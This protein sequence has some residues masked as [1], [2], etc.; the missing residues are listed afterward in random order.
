M[1]KTIFIIGLVAM[2]LLAGCGEK[3]ETAKPALQTAE[4]TDSTPA[5]GGFFKK[6][7]GAATATA[8]PAEPAASPAAAP[9]V[10]APSPTAAPVPVTAP[11]PAVAAKA[12]ASAPAKSAPKAAPAAP[13]KQAPPTVTA[14]GPVPASVPT[15]VP[16]KKIAAENEPVPKLGPVEICAKKANAFL[17]EIC[18]AKECLMN[19]QHPQCIAIS[20][21]RGSSNSNVN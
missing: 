6:P 12:A 19:S 21:E 11:A 2:G 3:T 16:D 13:K 18:L 10:V 15:A 14:A 20:K 8:A 1:K 9:V 4:T 17:K 7:P 5:T